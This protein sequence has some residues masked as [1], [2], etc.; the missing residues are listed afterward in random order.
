MSYSVLEPAVPF[1]GGVPFKFLT[2]QG[3]G[4]IE[5]YQTYNG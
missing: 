2:Y 1:G 4:R 5:A 3:V